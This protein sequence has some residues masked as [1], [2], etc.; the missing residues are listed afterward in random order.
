MSFVDSLNEI[1]RRISPE[2]AKYFQFK[3]HEEWLKLRSKAL[4]ARVG[5][6]GWGYMVKNGVWQDMSKP[7][8]YDLYH[9]DVSAADLKDSRVDPA[10]QIIY[11][12][13]ANGVE[14]KVGLMVDGKAR[15]GFATPSRRFSIFHEDIVDADKQVGFKDNGMPEFFPVESF[16]KMK[17]NQPHLVTFK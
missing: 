10:T 11:R 12:K 9:W 5:E 8:Y 17:D 15:R 14:S 4:T 16:V 1:G 3:D 13:A 7:K 2:T 6:D